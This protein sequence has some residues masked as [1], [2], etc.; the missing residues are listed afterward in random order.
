MRR[1][2]TS[3][4]FATISTVL[5]SCGGADSS[6]TKF[7]LMD[8]KARDAHVRYVADTSGD[9]AFRISEA[10]ASSG[11][12]TLELVNS[13]DVPHN[14]ALEGPNGKPI[15]ETDTVSEEITS[16]TAV[17]KPGEYV[18]YC[19]VPG[20]REAGMVGHLTVYPN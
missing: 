13:Q 19:T 4:A 12:I 2:V 14:V 11:K 16:T 5:M 18:V 15:A 1:L 9:L 6:P 8:D 7:P 10:S 3:V 17:V 20:H